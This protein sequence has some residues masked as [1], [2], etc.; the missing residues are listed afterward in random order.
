MHPCLVLVVKLFLDTL[1]GMTQQFSWTFVNLGYLIVSPA[2]PQTR[3]AKLKTHFEQSPT[4]PAQISYLM[5]HW[6]TGIP[7][8]ASMHSGAYD[9]LTLWE[10]IDEGEQFTPAKKWLICFPIVLY[11]LYDVVTVVH[12]RCTHSS[13]HPFTNRSAQV[14]AVYPLYTL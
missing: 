5:F 8:Q 13:D 10:Q 11:V 4:S 14:L 9:D 1:P 6:A 7:F 2:H 3:R 12:A